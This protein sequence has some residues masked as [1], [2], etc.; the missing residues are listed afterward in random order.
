MRRL[1]WIAP[2][3]AALCV[4]CTGGPD[5]VTTPEIAKSAD[6]VLQD[7]GVTSRYYEPGN[8][9]TV[10]LVNEAR[11]NA[12]VRSTV[13]HFEDLGYTCEPSYSFVAE[14]EGPGG[15]YVDLVALTMV[16]PAGANADVVYI[17]DVRGADGET[18][19][20]LR[21]SFGDD[22]PG[23][24]SQRLGEGVWVALADEAVGIGENPAAARLM[25]A[26]WL[27]CVIDRLAAGTTS[28]AVTCRFAIGLYLPCLAKC[29]LG[30]AI[31]AFVYCTIMQ[32]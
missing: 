16:A 17:L 32:L 25:W 21:V 11:E 13:L 8:A 23:W 30:H 28:C 31:F 27:R 10:Q 6:I 18:V 22:R 9:H 1:V 20:P 5:D 19:V 12:V 26:P 14:G 15:E 7:E 24:D 4:S 3:L 2:W 29:T